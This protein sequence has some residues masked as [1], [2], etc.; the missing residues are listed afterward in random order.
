MSATST[1]IT[2]LDFKK[3]SDLIAKCPILNIQQ[4]KIAHPLADGSTVSIIYHITQEI[5][6]SIGSSSITFSDKMS[7][8][9]KQ[10][11]IDA[12]SAIS[13]ETRSEETMTPDRSIEEESRESRKETPSSVTSGT[14]QRIKISS[15]ADG[16]N[17]ITIIWKKNEGVLDASQERARDVLI[18][19]YKSLM[20]I[21]RL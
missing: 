19:I 18:E 13:E 3:I 1:D 14:I 4:I 12:T 16:K 8:K 15:Y 10:E 7:I 21:Q 5:L 6:N 17:C 20:G 9:T 11:N 2:K